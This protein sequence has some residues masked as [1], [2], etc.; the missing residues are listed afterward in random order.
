MT[1]KVD[2]ISLFTLTASMRSWHILFWL[3]LALRPFSDWRSTSSKPFL[4]RT[5]SLQCSLELGLLGAS[6]VSIFFNCRP[7]VIFDS[8][9]T[10]HRAF[11]W[12]DSTYLFSCKHLS[13]C[14][15]SR[16]SDHRHSDMCMRTISSLCD[17]TLLSSSLTR[18]MSTAYQ[19]MQNYALPEEEL[20]K[21]CVRFENWFRVHPIGRSRA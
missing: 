20:A 10:P 2:S 14:N 6:L 4:R 11:F 3:G 17:D 19:L 16:L 13:L 21:R 9:S 12:H 1:A 7:S 18:S 15:S 5:Q 8:I